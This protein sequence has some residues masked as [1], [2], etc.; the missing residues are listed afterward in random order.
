[1]AARGIV[2]KGGIGPN[3]RQRKIIEISSL[4]YDEFD[5]GDKVEIDHPEEK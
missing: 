5:F 3:G 4:F 1:M 2:R